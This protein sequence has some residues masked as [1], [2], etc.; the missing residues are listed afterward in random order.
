MF[1]DDTTVLSRG[2]PLSSDIKFE[3]TRNKKPKKSGL[4]QIDI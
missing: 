2:D 4:F 1:A 3:Q